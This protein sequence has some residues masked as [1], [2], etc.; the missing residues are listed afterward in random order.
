MLKFSLLFKKLQSSRAN[1]ARIPRIK[2]AKFSGYHFYKNKN[3]WED[4]Q[5]CIGVPLRFSS[6]FYLYI[7]LILVNFPGSHIIFFNFIIEF[8]LRF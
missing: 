2:N 6:G 7:L 1:N 5:I 8:F 3:I 4:F